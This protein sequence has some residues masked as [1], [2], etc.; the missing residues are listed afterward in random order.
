MTVQA[1]A[2]SYF[3]EHPPG[4]NNAQ[5]HRDFLLAYP[6]TEVSYKTFNNWS[7]TWTT[8]GF[9][10]PNGRPAGHHRADFSAVRVEVKAKQ[11][12]GVPMMKEDIDKLVGWPFH[13]SCHPF[14]PH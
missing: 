1:K 5:L 2:A 13:T 7:K 10:R 9:I 11:N 8:Q 3:S 12:D 4:G 14:H 6:D